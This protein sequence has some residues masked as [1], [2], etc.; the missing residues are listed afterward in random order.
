[1]RDIELSLKK[2]Y[3]KM[4]HNKQTIIYSSNIFLNSILAVNSCICKTADQLPKTLI[5]ANIQENN[6]LYFV[7]TKSAHTQFSAR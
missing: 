4:F 6:Q 3:W 5:K 2:N 7:L 1:M